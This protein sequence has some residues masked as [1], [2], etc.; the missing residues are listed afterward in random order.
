MP[1]REIARIRVPTRVAALP[2]VGE[3]IVEA[4]PSV[5]DVAY[6]M[7]FF[8]RHIIRRGAFAASLE[9]QVAIP[10]FWSHG[11]QT[12]QLPV[13]ETIE[14]YE[15]DHGMRIVAQLYVDDPAVRRLWRSLAAGTLREWSIAYDVTTLHVDPDDEEL[16]EVLE[17]ELVE[18]SVELR[19]ANPETETLRVAGARSVPE[20]DIDRLARAVSK[21]LS[22]L[23]APPD[24][25][26]PPDPQRVAALLRRPSTRALLMPSKEA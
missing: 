21:V 10:I 17:A 19:G 16:I 5:F 14:A 11:W 1:D 23:P 15:D 26:R 2:D 20:I 12:D 6:R 22:R 3:G 18:V 24:D 4:Y 7:G 9:A 13:G 8:V 25:P